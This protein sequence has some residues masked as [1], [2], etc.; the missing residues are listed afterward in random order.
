MPRQFITASSTTNGKRVWPRHDEKPEGEAGHRARSRLHHHRHPR[1]QHRPK[2]NP[3]WGKWA[4]Y[5]GKTRRPAAYKTGT[6]SD[7]RDV[8]A[9]G[10]LA[11]PKDK[12][13]P[14][15]A[16]GVWMG[17]SNNS[18][19]D[20]SLSLDS[21]APLWS[22]ILDEVSKGEP[23]A[24]F[25]RHRRASRRDRR[26]VHRA[27]ARTVHDQDR[28]RSCSSPAPC[29]SSGRRSGSPATS[30]PRRGLLWQDG[31]VGPEGDPRLLQPQRGR[32]QPPVLAEGRT[33]LGRPR[34]EGSRASAAVRE[35]TRTA[36]FYDG[37][38][39]RSA[40]TWGA[41][42]A[43]KATCPLPATRL[44]PAARRPERLLRD[45]A[46]TG[47]CRS[48]SHAAGEAHPKPSDGQ[49][50][51]GDAEADEAPMTRGPPQATPRAA[52]TDRSAALRT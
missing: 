11:P 9:Y 47:P 16:V 31:C 26:R 8:A 37:A 39:R 48:A 45:S 35:G 13:A 30:T 7:N 41:P 44:R 40:R 14:A 32:V 33:Q 52:P 29:R 12:K 20:G 42:F 28:S 17:N 22:A 3:Y 50:Q 21:S 15:L 25:K 1:R 43:P 38:F 46:P 34:G 2:V 5:D 49:D 24:E 19:N 27:Q 10:F 4:I 23:I 36:Y 51:D 18:P 6:T